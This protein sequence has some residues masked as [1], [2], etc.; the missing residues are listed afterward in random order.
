MRFLSTLLLLGAAC[1]TSLSAQVTITGKVTDEKKEALIGVN[2]QIKN[3]TQGGITDL[4]GNYNLEIP[5]AE[6]ILV[7]SYTG[8]QTQEISVK[9]RTI[10]DVVM[11]DAT[12]MI[13][14]VVVVGYG[15]QRKS[16]LTGSVGSIKSTELQ[17]VAASNVTQA[18]QGKIAGVNVSS[19]SG[20]PGEGPVIRIRGTGTLNNAN[21]IYVVDGLILDNIDFLNSSDIENI[22]VLKDASSAAIYGTR[23]ANGVV[24]ITT[25]KGIRGQKARFS[26]NAY[27]GIQQVAKKI[28]LST[29]A[30]YARL[31]NEFYTNS[32]GKPP[33]ANPDAFGTGTDWQNEIFRDAS[34]QNY[35]LNVSGGSEAMTYS[36]SGD[37]FLQDGIIKSSYFNRYSL[38]VNNEYNLIKGVKLGHN[39]SFI[40]SNN[41]REPGGIVF[42][43]YAA[44]PTVIAINENGKFG[45]T[46]TNS[47][48]SNPAAQLRYN[49]Y[50]RGYG[51]QING[52][53]Y[54]EIYPIK[55]LTARN[56]FGFNSINSR[57]K[58]Y[59]PQFEVDD[60]QRNPQSR[61]NAEFSRYNDWQWE[62]TLNYSR[63]LGVHRFSILAG[64]TQQARGGERIGGSRQRLIGDTEEFF[65]LDAGD[66][67][68]ATNYNIGNNPE[69]YQSYL[70]RANYNFKERYL[71]TATFRRDGSSK[72][73]SERRYGNFPAFAVAWRVKEE[74]FLKKVE[75]IDNL[76]LRASWGR[77]GNDK[78]PSD[79][80]I[81]TV[82]NNLS[83]V[84]G[85]AET[86]NFG[87]SLISLANPFL[88]WEQTSSTDLGAEL[89][90]IDNRLTLEVEYY[91]RN[92]N[93]IL[94]PV[95][96][97][98]YVGSASNPY[99][100]AANVRNSGLD[101][102]LNY[103]SSV[104]KFNYHLGVLG[105]TLKN[106]VRSLGTGNEALFAN[107]TRTTVGRPIGS[108]YGYKVVGVYQNAEEIAQHPA[109]EAVVPGDLRFEDANGDGI[110]DSQDRTWLGSPIPNLVYG[111]NLG[112]DAYG[113]DFSI[114]F[115]GVSGNKIYNGKRAARGFGIP[116]Y[117]ASFLNRWTGPGTSNTEPRITN[118]GYNYQISDRF[119]ENG[120]Y[121]RLRSAVLGFSLPKK[122]LEHIKLNS[123]RVYASGN[124]VFTWTKYSGFTPE[125]SSENVLQVGID[126]GVYPLSR[127]WLAGI[128]ITF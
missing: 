50:N 121:F 125:I 4:E 9:G 31:V 42:N 6:A 48:V 44:D 20:R 99:V 33:Y 79:A 7:F 37:A 80:A 62:N 96:I 123:L 118:G 38:R 27:N 101:L 90:F 113:F 128:N 47:N 34:I 49:S 71:F 3:S 104:G 88:Q 120:A 1:F 29:G 92:T 83:A 51:Q 19:A 45:S 112:F 74:P 59:E 17:K 63:Q 41:N 86:L 14:E 32:G 24:L 76:K 106:E 40:S 98:D 89:G 107:A 100:N 78:F 70:F 2:I 68:T 82:T 105:S 102:T 5:D 53:A 39:L 43:S 28:D 65:Y 93:K 12:L 22:E 36:I 58:S 54:V 10:V 57:G 116:N 26:F 67:E 124:N 117:E 69:R 30:E 8:F 73:G 91:S 35:N 114:D 110:I 15:T 13:N 72:F 108:F 119:L 109:R 126:G 60:K 77:L 46:S 94:V 21:P 103:R 81:P 66:V 61:I 115:N 56:S 55:N 25:R 85:G 11:S 52:N 64:Y 122:L 75:F 111:F 127:T 95:P 18:L 23:G 97:P 84:F 87:A 16:D